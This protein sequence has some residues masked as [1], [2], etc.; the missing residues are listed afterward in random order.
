MACG[1]P[2][3]LGVHAQG[4]VGEGSQPGGEP[5]TVLLQQMEEITVLVLHT[6][7]PHASIRSVLELSTADG[8]PGEATVHAPKP[9]E[10]VSSR[11][12]GLALI[13]HPKMVGEAVLDHLR[14]QPLAK[15]PLVLGNEMEAG[16]HGAHGEPAQ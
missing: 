14:Y 12:F 13:L 11:G 7:A 6:T 16:Q 1:A 3:M 4:H 15:L 10:L 8:R 5:V 9:V 2:G